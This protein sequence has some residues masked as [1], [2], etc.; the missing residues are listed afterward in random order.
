MELEVHASRF[1]GS[2]LP[3]QVTGLMYRP[4]RAYSRGAICTPKKGK[5]QYSRYLWRIS[6]GA[7]CRSSG[8][9]CTCHCTGTDSGKKQIL[10]SQAWY[11]ILPAIV[12]V[13]PSAASALLKS[14]DEVTLTSW[15]MR[16][17]PVKT[18][19][20]SLMAGRK[21]AFEGG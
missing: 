11:S 15:R 1:T 9:T 16:K 21:S 4:A 19:T 3:R 13:L 14:A 6:S 7:R 20:R 5:F 2:R 18:G 10:L 17:V 12:R 8:R